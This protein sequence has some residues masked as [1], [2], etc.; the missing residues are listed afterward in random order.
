MDTGAGVGGGVDDRK[1]AFQFTFS[2]KRFS[3]TSFVPPKKGKKEKSGK[4]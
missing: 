4:L 3:L 1:S 2:V